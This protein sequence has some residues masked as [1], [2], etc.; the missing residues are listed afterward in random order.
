MHLALVEEDVT[1]AL[2]YLK[3]LLLFLQGEGRISSPLK[4]SSYQE[5]C[6]IDTVL[7]PVVVLLS[8]IQ[9]LSEKELGVI[10]SY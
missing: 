8:V 9:F 1:L 3:L 2:M 10:L 6:G 4:I 7:Y 5:L